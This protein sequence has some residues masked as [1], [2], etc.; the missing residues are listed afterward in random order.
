MEETRTL[1]WAHGSLT[2][3][4]L[5]A[6][7]APVRFDL[8]SGQ[9]VEPFYVAPWSQDGS[10]SAAEL[11][12]LPGILQRLRGEWP[13]VPF[14]A[15]E[16]VSLL[17]DWHRR[18]GQPSPLPPD[19]PPHG[20]S[21]NTHWSWLESGPDSLSMALDY[22][23]DHPIAR[24]EREIIPDHATSAVD[25]VLRVIPRRACRLPIGL[26]PT[27]ALPHQVGAA[28]VTVPSAAH[29]LSYPGSLEPGSEV[30][31]PD[32]VF[33]SLAEAP[34][35]GGGTLDASS[36]PFE[37]AG[38]DLVQLVGVKNGYA[39]LEN[40]QAGYRVSLEWEVEHFPN[41]LLWFS[42][43]GRQQAPWFGRNVALGM[44]PICSA[45]DLGAGMS[46][47]SNPISDFGVSTARPFEPREVFETRYRIAVESV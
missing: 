29:M 18:L 9:S 41:L 39:A 42:N 11:T 27:F 23:S 25:L 20:P 46:C 34:A 17:G 40:R 19:A 1:D 7:L 24:V 14:G 44:E 21:S 15:D 35:Y 47:G 2:V 8:P 43:R 31:A 32:K 37:A 22:P 5:G 30:F 26:H 33:S 3:Q 10:L 16:P 6:M 28:S 12:A 45:F 13:C 4:S 36:V 38:E